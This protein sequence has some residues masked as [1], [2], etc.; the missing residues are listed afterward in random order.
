MAAFC[1]EGS[2]LPALDSCL[3]KTFAKINDSHFFCHD[4]KLL[5][6]DYICRLLWTE[7]ERG[8]GLFLGYE[9]SHLL[10]NKDNNPS[11][12]WVSRLFLHS[13]LS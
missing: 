11:V 4:V 13:L 12:L 7:P 10:A 8:V 3:T 9:L 2:F 6:N 5:T 1:A